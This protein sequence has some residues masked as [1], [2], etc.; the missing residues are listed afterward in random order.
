M[1]W[2]A[3]KTALCKKA[4]RLAD[5]LVD[6]PLD[7][8]AVLGRERRFAH[9]RAQ[10]VAGMRQLFG[11]PL[12]IDERRTQIVRDAVDEH[13]VF[14]RL[15]MQRLVRP[16]QFVGPARK[17]VLEARL[18]PF[19]FAQAAARLVQDRI[20]MRDLVIAGRRQSKRR[21]LGEPRRVIGQLPQPA[22][23]SARKQ[24]YRQCRKH[25]RADDGGGGQPLLLRERGGGIL[26]AQ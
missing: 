12:Q 10:I 16:S 18:H 26:R 19:G 21:V 25:E 23:Q 3:R 13:L 22:A 5:I 15:L 4:Q 20:E 11:K 1:I 14:L 7:M 9:R 6:E 8:L 17:V 24:E 2:A